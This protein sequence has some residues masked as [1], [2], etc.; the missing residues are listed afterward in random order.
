MDTTTNIYI[1][2]HILG[3]GGAG[4]AASHLF[5]KPTEAHLPYHTHTLTVSLSV[6]PVVEATEEVSLDSP[7]RDVL[8]SDG[9]SPA[10]T[11]ITPPTSVITPR[12]GLAH[13]DMFTHSSFDEVTALT[14]QVIFTRLCIYFFLLLFKILLILFFYLGCPVPLF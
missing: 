2:L 14:H 1:P 4:K 12:I 10:I 5:I 8:L 3:K 9:P 6:C 13:D 7:E 11:P